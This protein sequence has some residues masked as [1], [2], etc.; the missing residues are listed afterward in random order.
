M[1]EPGESICTY[2]VDGMAYHARREP[3]LRWL[4]AYGRVFSVWDQQ[5]SGNL[6]F[7]VEGKFGKLFVKYAGADT[8]NYRGRPSDTV[9]ALRAA[10]PLYEENDHPA[11]TRLL[12]HGPAGE[13]YA[14]VFAWRDAPAL[15]PAPGDESVRALVRRLPPARSLKMLDMVFDLHAYL[16]AEGIVAVDFWDGN[17]LIDFVRDEAIVCDIDLYRRKPAVND[18]GRMWGSGRFMAPEEYQ[19]GAALDECTTVYNMGALAFEFFG[20]NE[21]RSEKSWIGPPPLYAVARRATRESKADRFPSMRAYLD[22]WR[23]AVGHCRGL[24]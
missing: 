4:S 7:G 12:A 2:D 9:A 23:E 5:S 3:D 14:A 13:G 8:V 18:R 11:L 16:A 15:R 1:P 20:D 6:C 21:D 10:M 19:R 17:V 24:D 22:A